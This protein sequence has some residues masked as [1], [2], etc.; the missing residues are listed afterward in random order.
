MDSQVFETWELK[1]Y[2]RKLDCEER[3]SL[4]LG[5]TVWV[6]I[7]IGQAL[8]CISPGREVLGPGMALKQQH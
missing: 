5:L 1:G 8:S 4:V 7:P 2:V 6:W 3:V